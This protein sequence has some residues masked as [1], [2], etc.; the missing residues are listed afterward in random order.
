MPFSLDTEV[1]GG[2]RPVRLVFVGKNTGKGTEHAQAKAEN[3]T[4]HRKKL[5]LLWCLKKREVPF[6]RERTAPETSVRVI[7]CM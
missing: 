2:Q 5:L 7:F 4:F 3:R 1:E 6:V